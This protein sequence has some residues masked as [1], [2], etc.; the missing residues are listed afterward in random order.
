MAIQWDASMSTGLEAIDAQ[1][2]QLIQWLNDLLEAMS[3]GKGRQELA[4]VLAQL[5]DYTRTHFGYEEECMTRY[6][7]P[8]ASANASAHKD[9]IRILGEFQA[10]FSRTGATSHM[11]VSLENEL[12]QW[13]VLHIKRTDTQ[14]LP[15]VKATA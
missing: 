7:C 10:E 9:F 14:L 3:I 5:G 1:H 13:L 12:M 8:V 4:G 6:K 11:V 15:C 2:K